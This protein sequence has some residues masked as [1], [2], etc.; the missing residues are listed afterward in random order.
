MVQYRIQV[1]TGPQE[2]AAAAASSN[3]NISIALVGTNGESIKKIL[4]PPSVVGAVQQ[5]NI[6]TPGDLG[7]ILCVRLYKACVPKLLTHPW[8]C[9]YVHVISPDRKRYQFPCHRWICG[10]QALEILEGKGV[11]LAGTVSPLILQRRRSELDRNRE[12]YRWKVYAEGAPYCIDAETTQD[13]SS[14]EQYSCEK[15]SSFG[16]TLAASGLEATLKGYLLRCDPWKDLNEIN[17]LFSFKKTHMP[18]LTSQMWNVDT[19][20][21]YQYLNGVNPMSVRKC[22]KIPGNFPVT[23]D[24]V[25]STLGSSTDLQQ[26]LESGNIFLA[27]YNILEGIPTNTINGK[28]QYLAAPLCLLWKS[29]QDHLIPIAIQLGQQ[30]GPENPIFVTSDPEWDW[31]LAKIWVRYAEFQ[32]HELDHHL[33]RTHL[34]AEVICL[35]TVRN[36]PT[37]QPLLKL[38]L[39]HF[40]FT[41]EINILARSQLIGPGG[42]FDKAFVTGNGGVPILVRKALERL[43]YTSL[44]LP[45]DLKDRG[46]ESIPKHYYREDG[47]KIWS[48]MEK[49]A[50]DI[51]NYYYKDDDMVSKDPELQAWIKEI[52]QRGF[53]ERESSGIPSSLRSRVEVI[54]FATMVMFSCSAQHAAV[55]SGQFDFYSWMPNAPSS[56]RQPPP[57]KKGVTTFQSILDAMPEMNTTALAMVTVW[58]LSKEPEDKKPLGD[59]KN[60]YFLEETPLKFSQAFQNRMAEIS[61]DIQQRNKSMNLTY[62]YL[63]PKVIECSVSI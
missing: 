30:P 3:D 50:S 1:A 19:F 43:T 25:A 4:G 5:Y 63:D 45:D 9:K 42:L 38:L 46:M 8:F 62:L 27:D 7:E 22:T 51:V 35:A 60:S 36:L 49:F 13:L 54:K 37:Q 26:E 20:F 44:C 2:D 34:L 52:F 28:K 6:Q 23:Q 17:N 57:T 59:Y 40:D 32:L 39:P 18:D 21:G 10:V 24:M 15:L 12:K 48:A 14:N 61:K 11:V 47:M 56:L 41:L 29:L 58:L 31:T 33:L 55:N 16:F 53:L